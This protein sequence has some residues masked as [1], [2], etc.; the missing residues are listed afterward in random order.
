MLHRVAITCTPDSMADVT[1][2]TE[3]F[4]SQLKRT[5]TEDSPEESY[6]FVRAV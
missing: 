2:E 3:R 4:V 1:R 6:T 5:R